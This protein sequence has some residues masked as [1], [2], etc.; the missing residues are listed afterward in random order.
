MEEKYC[1]AQRILKQYNQEHLLNSYEKLEEKQKEELLKEILNIDFKQVENLYKEINNT[2]KN[3]S[4]K[5]EPIEY[6]DE[7]KL[8]DNQ[9]DVYRQKGIEVLKEGK[10]AVITMAGGQGTRLGH[11]GPKGTFK[12]GIEPDK[13]LFEILCE[14][15]KEVQEEYAVVT[16]WYIMTS[17]ENNSDTVNFFE[18]NNYFN[19][20]KEAIKFFKQGELPMIDKNGKI[21]LTE[22][23]LIKEAADGHGGIFEAMFKNNVVEDLKQK[24]IE[25]IFIGPIDNPLAPMTDELMVGYSVVEG[26]LAT[27]KSIVKAN[28]QEKVGV[29]CKKDGRPSVVE[30]TEITTEM[31][32][33]TDENG[34]L[35]FGESHINCN[36]FNIKA[37]EKIGNEKLPYH[38]AFKKATYM[39]EKGNII[40]PTEPNGYKFESF[41]FDAFEKIDKMG[42][43]RGTREKEFAPVKNA[44][45]VDSPQTARE[46]YK[47]YY[48]I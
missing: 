1:E 24:N 13:S 9:K 43:L 16:P 40:K 36:L 27:G 5:I 10:Y 18:E 44:E 12:L 34:E 17:K 15:L 20:P 46:L 39:D 47:K 19:Y 45:G 29:F 38:A 37:I 30:Y 23:G 32:E 28:P 33:E 4:Q 41:I 8:T 42:I 48:G 35:K 7:S 6:V 25:W 26:V 2:D 14:K 21:F 22:E 11:N 3:N 31:A